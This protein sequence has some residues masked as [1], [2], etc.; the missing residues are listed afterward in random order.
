MDLKIENSLASKAP[1]L[2]PIRWMFQR[3]QATILLQ[4]REEFWAGKFEGGISLMAA[5][6]GEKTAYLW[7]GQKNNL[8]MGWC[9]IQ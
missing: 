6:G 4:I 7:D 9:Q 2:C 3:L 5:I 1:K 8:E